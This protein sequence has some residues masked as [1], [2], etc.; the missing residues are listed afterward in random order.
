MPSLPVLHRAKAFAALVYTFAVVMLGTTMPTPMYGLYQ[1]KM[2]FSVLIITV[3]YAVY[4]VGVLAALLAFGRWS[5][6]L[7][8][9][10]LLLA[11]VILSALSAVVFLTAGQVW[12]LL[13][14][15]VLSGLSAGV[16]VGA[17]TVA[18]VEM[19]PKR[20]R[21]QAPIIATAANMGGLGLGPLLAG[22]LVAFI[23]APLHLTFVVHLVLLALAAVLVVLAPETVSVQ[24]GARPQRQRLSVP[25]QVRA[26]FVLASVAGFAGFAVLGLFTA[27][28]PTFL[29]QVIGIGNPAIAGLVVFVVFAASTVAQIA[30]RGLAT[31][32]ALDAG[33]VLLVVGMVLVAFALRQESIAALV[34]GGAVAGVGQGMAFS[35]GMEAVTSALPS[36][37]RAEVTSTFFVVVYV[38]ISVPVIG[39]G[40]LAISCGLVTAGL[41]FALAVAVLAIG[42]LFALVY[43]QRRTP[44]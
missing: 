26:V 12:Q 19:A 39:V 37:R 38:A 44:R 34:L 30:L 35:K 28:A 18:V 42:A 11:G 17:A 1:D 20:W 9:R 29:A 8:R 22:L 33:C 3:I 25:P 21:R 2:D 16:Y 32:V 36:D 41:V 14:G 4:A 24:T 43:R 15:R 5:D 7:G 31:T 40:A 23:P 27:V 13:L 10:P 6:T